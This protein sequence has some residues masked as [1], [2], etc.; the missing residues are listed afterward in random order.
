MKKFCTIVTFTLAGWMILESMIGF[1]RKQ[2]ANIQDELLKA[3][4]LSLL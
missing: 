4:A 3:M 2:I 1:Q